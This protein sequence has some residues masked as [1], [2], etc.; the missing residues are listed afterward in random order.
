MTEEKT[1][2]NKKNELDDAALEKK[3]SSAIPLRRIV[4]LA[5]LLLVTSLALQHQWLG[6]ERAAPIDGFCPFGGVTTFL[7]LVTT[8][9]FL[10]RVYWASLTLMAITLLMT[11]VFG[12]AFC[13]YL[14]PLGTLQEWM[15]ALGRKLGFKKDYELPANVDRYAR[16]LKYVMMVAI[17][18]LSFTAGDLVFRTYDPFVAL[19]HFGEESE[20]LLVGYVLLGLVLAS[21]L[22]IKNAWCRYFCPLGAFYG[23]LSKLKLYNIQRDADACTD[24]GAC[25]R[26]CIAGLD[27]QHSDVV[28]ELDCTSCMSCVES[29]PVNALKAEVKG[30]EVTSSNAMAA[31]VGASFIVMVLI[32]MATGTWQTMPGSNI[33][34]DDGSID[35]ANI[36]GS[37]TLGNIIKT[38][39]V[40]LEVFT[41]ELGVPADADLTLKLKHV[42]STYDLKDAEGNVIETYHF[43]EVIARE[44]G[45]EYTASDH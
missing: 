18:Y 15:R 19:M 6:I 10:K 20:E 21:S 33:A 36:R 25:N 13:G 30:K 12:R 31:A 41:R 24:C 8:G 23:V 42:G 39:G 4:Q 37:N 29:C 43:R 7:T 17:I 2:E 11:V 22:F 1:V 16:Y 44:L 28:K 45:L 3:P 34:T 9:A 26:A 32:A 14:C 5:V 38:T 35:V 40:P 27:V